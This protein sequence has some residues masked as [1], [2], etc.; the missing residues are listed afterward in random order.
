MTEGDR[1]VTNEGTQKR[2]YEYELGHSD[3]ELRRLATQAALVDPMT[4]QYL[5]RAGLKTGMRVLDIGSGAGDVA[6]LA[7]E[8]VGP[9]GIV[10][11]SDRS[12]KALEAA[13]ARA[14]ERALD[15]VTFHECDPATSV[16][17]RPFDAIVGR[18]V[19]MFSADPVA[20]LK[21]IAKHLRP[22]GIIAFHEVDWTGAASVPSAPIYDNCVRCV[23]ETFRKVGTNPN[24]G[25]ALHSAFIRAGL[26]AP[27]MAVSALAGGS[28]ISSGIGLISDLAATMAPVME[29]MGVISISELDPDSLHERIRAEVIANQ[30]VVIGR[31]EVGAWSRV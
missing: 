18:Y 16:F 14:K 9:G 17:D 30:S 21:G 20:M 6:F 26:P 3:R 22:G 29:Q 31:Y 4:K 28:D 8:I 5:H 24:M 11:G 10:V 7:A 12:S 19:L 1:A 27:I 23:V 13:R 15:N 2:H 25:L